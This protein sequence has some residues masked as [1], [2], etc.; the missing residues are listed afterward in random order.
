[1][2]TLKNVLIKVQFVLKSC[3]IALWHDFACSAWNFASASVNVTQLPTTLLCCSSTLLHNE[4]RKLCYYFFSSFLC[5]SVSE[6]IKSGNTCN[7]I[8]LNSKAHRLLAQPCATSDSTLYYSTVAGSYTA[9]P[10]LLHHLLKYISPD[11]I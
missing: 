3:S 9:C 5:F 1:M 4:G 7:S 11:L 10:C 2:L 8:S 6:F